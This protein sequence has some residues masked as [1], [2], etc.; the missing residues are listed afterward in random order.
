MAGRSDLVSANLSRPKPGRP[1]GQS[2]ALLLVLSAIIALALGH[3]LGQ[4]PVGLIYLYGV[5]SLLTLLSYAWDKYAAKK[6]WQR[7][8]ERTLHLLAVIGGWPGALVAQQ[9]LRHK[10]VK[11]RFRVVFYLTLLINLALVYCWLIKR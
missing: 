10:T 2:L 7:V 9:W 6:G 8:P 4:I 5:A 1:R 3:E 11:R